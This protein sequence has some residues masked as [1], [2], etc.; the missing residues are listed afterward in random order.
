MEVYLEAEHATTNVSF[1]K[2]I[3]VSFYNVAIS[4][5]KADQVLSIQLVRNV[6]DVSLN[7]E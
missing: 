6:W 3:K 7:V 2:F 4:R 5:K 1:F